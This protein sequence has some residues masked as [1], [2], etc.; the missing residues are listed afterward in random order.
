MYVGRAV[1]LQEEQAAELLLASQADALKT[2]SKGKHLTTPLHKAIDMGS[3]KFV[4]RFAQSWRED[5]R[6]KR[7]VSG[8]LDADCNGVTPLLR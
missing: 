6:A 3:M 8:S 2:M 1:E 7:I 5:A 4:K